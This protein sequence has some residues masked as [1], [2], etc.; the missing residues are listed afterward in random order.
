MN[1]V[2]EHLQIII[3]VAGAI[4]YWIN[5]R[6][7]EKAGQEADYDEDGIPENRPA[8]RM[9]T[10]TRELSP[11]NRSGTDID[12]EER[13]RRIREEIQR[14]IAER[15]GRAPG[16]APAPPAPPPMPR[17]D[18]FRPVF[19]EEARPMPPPIRRAEPAPTPPP[20]PAPA[21][22]AVNPYD[23]S[24]ALDRQRRLAEQLEE[25]EARRSEARR[26]ASQT[27]G[28]GTAQVT[29]TSSGGVAVGS[30]SIAAELRDPRA[31]RRAFV[32]REVLSAPV[33]LR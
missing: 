33:A 28:D 2:L 14:K 32:L 7:R 3:V 11:A 17:L 21:P 19:Q 13:A 30:R 4:A 23:D 15:R 31:L 12:Q 18:P 25:L 16:A 5:Q 20:M 9:E 6:G 22:Q 26:M 1:W 8:P 24:A 10:Q 29:T 27:R